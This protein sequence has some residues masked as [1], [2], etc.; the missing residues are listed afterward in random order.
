MSATAKA[1]SRTARWTALACV[2]VVAGMTGLAFASAP[3][4]DLF[5]K[6][7]GYD[8]TPRVG[9]AP[10]AFDDGGALR[11]LTVHFDTNVAPNLP[12]RF[13]AETRSVEAAPG[14]TKTVFFKVTNAGEKPA[15]GIATFNVQPG[16]MGSY[17]V[18]V[19]CFCFD[20]H[21]LQPGESMDFPLVFYVEPSLRKDAD[22]ADLGEMTLSYTYFASRNGTPQAAVAGTENRGKGQ[23][24]GQG[25]TNF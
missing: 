1:T 23:G 7:T 18:K 15:T 19:Q 11:P 5:C 20:E 25:R 8:G 24:N 16:L 9:A 17:F 21:T 4:Y 2:G 13:Q 6:A 10:A 22:I 3:L 12:W 14:Q